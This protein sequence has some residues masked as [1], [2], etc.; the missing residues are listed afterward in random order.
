M[1]R[2]A[3]P[4][5]LSALLTVTGI[6]HFAVP[7]TYE[8]IIPSFVPAHRAVVYASGA[9]ELACAALVAH[10]RTRRIGGWA[11]VALFVVVFP[12]NVKMALDATTPAAKA[13]T[14]LRLPLQ[15]P[16]ILWAR[17]VARR[18]ASATPAMR[19]GGARWWSRPTS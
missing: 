1:R 2:D 18:V 14:Y 5:L 12:A 11:T 4:Y 6:A 3:A 15:V 19:E 13:A 10:R 17:A 16:L 7:V 8:R 9:T